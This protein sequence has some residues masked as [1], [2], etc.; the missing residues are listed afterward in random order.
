M[1]RTTQSATPHSVGYEVSVAREGG[2]IQATEYVAEAWERWCGVTPWSNFMRSFGELGGQV[3][4]YCG[5][6]RSAS[7]I[8]LCFTLVMPD[9]TE[10][11][12]SRLRDLRDAVA[13]LEE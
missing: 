6:P 8:P 12:G 9:G 7:A 2:H 3:I 13:E 4:W 5:M 10:R 1:Q 11:N